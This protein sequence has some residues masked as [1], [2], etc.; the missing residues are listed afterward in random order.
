MLRHNKENGFQWKSETSTPGAQAQGGGRLRVCPG[1]MFS[2]SRHR[3]SPE[4]LC[5]TWAR[6]TPDPRCWHLAGPPFC[7]PANTHLGPSVIPKHISCYVGATE[8][9]GIYG[10]FHCEGRAWCWSAL[11][12]QIG[13]THHLG[14]KV[15]MPEHDSEVPP[16]LCILVSHQAP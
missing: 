4:Q 9:R 15:E 11:D 8:G 10:K 2:L 12:R 5:L 7:P 1:L 14:D 3:L 16:Y 13:P 6:P